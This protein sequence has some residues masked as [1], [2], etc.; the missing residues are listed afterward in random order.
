MYADDTL[1][2]DQGTTLESS[3]NACQRSLDEVT[4]WCN[5]NKLTV[6]IGKTKTMTIV[7][8]SACVDIDL[9]VHID[10]KP[11]QHV[12]KYKYLGVIMD[13]KLCMNNHIEHII[14]ASYM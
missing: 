11:L 8:H 13:D 7:P 6:N 14:L 5:L 12:R 9:F 1:L 3:I 2:I 10:G 4:W